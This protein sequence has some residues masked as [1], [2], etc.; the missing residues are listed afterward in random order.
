MTL[1]RLGVPELPPPFL[2]LTRGVVTEGEEITARCV[3]PGERAIYFYFYMDSRMILEK[4][5]NSSQSEERFHL[6]DV[7]THKIHCSYIVQ[8]DLGVYKS[9][10]SST[11]TVLV[12]GTC[13]FK[14][15]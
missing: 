8:V 11:V 10:N 1:S 5:V 6:K 15:L 13:V 2:T 9:E 3:T 12:K 7:G 14:S 4:R